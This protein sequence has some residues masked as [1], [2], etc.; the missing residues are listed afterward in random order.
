MATA[1]GILLITTTPSVGAED[2]GSNRGVVRRIVECGGFHLVRVNAAANL[3]EVFTTNISVRNRNS[4]DSVTIERIAIHDIFGNL[5][6]DAGV[7]GG[8]ALPLNTDL[9]PPLDVTVVPPDANYYLSTKHI[10]GLGPLPA[11]NQ[12]G[13][14][15]SIRIQYSTSGRS[16]LVAVVGS[17]L[18][19]QRVQI[20]PS[21][22][23]EGE[24]HT[25][26]RQECQRL[27]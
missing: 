13:F 24:E 22:F 9:V 14:N 8:S 4:N 6:F 26:A 19:R 12:N 20:G 17:N 27:N 5:V 10:W 1:L 2:E 25:R 16:D 3:S 7:A 21:T 23:V 11:G 15:L 18:V